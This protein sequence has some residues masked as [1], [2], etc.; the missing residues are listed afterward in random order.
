M[1]RK[2]NDVL[3]FIWITFL[4]LFIT[5]NFTLILLLEFSVIDI[6]FPFDGVVWAN[7]CGLVIAIYLLGWLFNLVWALINWI[8]ELIHSYKLEKY[9]KENPDKEKEMTEKLAKDFE[10]LA[11]K[12]R[13]DLKEKK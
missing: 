9:Y 8:G 13:D 4:P 7:I 3:I 2:I 10:D 12:L 11:Q 5:A 1:K 6:E